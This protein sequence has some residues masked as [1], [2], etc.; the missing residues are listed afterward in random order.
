M[1]NIHF[2]INDHRLKLL[3][4]ELIKHPLQNSDGRQLYL[5]FCETIINLERAKLIASLLEKL[6][7]LV[8]K[9]HV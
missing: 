4:L 5:E 9:L 7:A 8:S 6:A 3:L 2:K 1:S